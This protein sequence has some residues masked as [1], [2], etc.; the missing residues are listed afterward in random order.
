M[1][2][3]R[4]GWLRISTAVMK[5]EPSKVRCDVEEAVAVAAGAIGCGDEDVDCRADGDWRGWNGM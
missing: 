2:S 5:D 3:T 4:N 1:A